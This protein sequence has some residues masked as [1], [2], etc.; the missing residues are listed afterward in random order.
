MK[1]VFLFSLYSI[2]AKHILYAHTQMSIFDN[3]SIKTPN[4]RLVRYTDRSD[5]LKWLL[6]QAV[7]DRNIEHYNAIM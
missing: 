1:L 2:M 3:I 7:Y 5:V 4:N 6:E